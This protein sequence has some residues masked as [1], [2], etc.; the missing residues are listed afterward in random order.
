MMVVGGGVKFHQLG[1]GGW[2][3]V[4]GAEYQIHSATLK[5]LTDSQFRQFTSWCTASKTRQILA[6]G[7]NQGFI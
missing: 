3:V 2:V 4:A 6:S 1:V 5:K 7:H